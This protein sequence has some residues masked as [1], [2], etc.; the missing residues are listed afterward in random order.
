M[1]E[2]I[3]LI[4]SGSA[5][6]SAAVPGAVTPRKVAIIG[7][8]PAGCSAAIYA[9]RAC[10]DPI[11]FTGAESGG[12][13]SMT[14]AV[15][16]YP[17]F[18]E[19][20]M[21]PQLMERMLEQAS[22]CGA[23]VL[24]RTIKKVNFS[25]STLLLE[26]DL[27][28]S[29]AFNSVIIA[30]GAQAKWLGIPSEEKFRGFGLSSC[31]TCDGFFFRGQ[32]V[33]IVGGGNTAAEEALYMSNIASSVTLIHRRE[34]LRAERTLQKRVFSDPKIKVL[35]N[36]ELI[37]VL[38]EEGSDKHV[39]GALIR[40]NKTEVVTK[41]DLQAIFVAIG[42]SPNT[43]IFRDSLSCDESGYIITGPDSTQTSLPGVF[44]AGDVQDRIF[45]QAITAAGSGCMAALEAEKFLSTMQFTS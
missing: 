3:A 39:T 34:A 40:D 11:L 12:Q 24:T 13:L 10:L 5:N 36:S 42:H 28:Q 2:K 16:N 15:E 18:P 20:I 14:T 1:T 37:E 26:D 7:S 45:R 21:G 35:W 31:A 6:C 17:G 27:K 43:K 30:T 32:H 29:Y 33:A 25:T 9:A 22:H 23:E 44:A 38:G 8:G 19:V 4:E 41:L